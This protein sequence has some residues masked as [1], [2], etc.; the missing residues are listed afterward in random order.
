[1]LTVIILM[2]HTHASVVK[3]IL[4]MEQYAQISMNALQVLILALAMPIVPITQDHLH[5]HAI[6]AILVME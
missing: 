4:E 6:M 3:V 5:A 2:D 1:M